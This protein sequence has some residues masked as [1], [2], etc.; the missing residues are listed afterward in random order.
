MFRRNIQQ[1]QVARPTSKQI[2]RLYGR[3]SIELAHR[4]KEGAP[5][6]TEEQ[7]FSENHLLIVQHALAMSEHVRPGRPV[8]MQGEG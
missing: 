6:H 3:P 4:L 8:S 1:V 7:M 5:L 2:L